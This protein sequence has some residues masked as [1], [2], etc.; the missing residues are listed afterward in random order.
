MRATQRGKEKEQL[1]K[2]TIF[3][4]TVCGHLE[5]NSPYWEKQ[6]DYKKNNMYILF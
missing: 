5:K 2:E 3:Q 1:G 4:M 6:G